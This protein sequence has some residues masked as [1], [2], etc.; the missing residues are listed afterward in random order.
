M[1]HKC[2]T[3][4]T[5]PE[6]IRIT[7]EA[8]LPLLVH[9]VF[10]RQIHKIRGEDQTQEANVKCGYQLLAQKGHTTAIMLLTDII[11][12]IKTFIAHFSHM[13]A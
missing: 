2:K 10:L 5:P 1:G 12:N 8:R 3:Y 9:C 13:L 6:C 7:R 11:L 4:N